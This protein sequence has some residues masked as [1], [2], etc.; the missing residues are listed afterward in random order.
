M[1]ATFRKS[2]IE[3]DY[4]APNMVILLLLATCIIID[5]GIK[6]VFLSLNGWSNFIPIRQFWHPVSAM[7]VM[8]VIGMLLL[9]SKPSFS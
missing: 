7:A 3:L 8:R 1:I 5:A 4:T 2:A 6:S 9:G